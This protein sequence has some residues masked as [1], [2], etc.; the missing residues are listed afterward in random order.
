MT[1][2]GTTTIIML[3]CESSTEPHYWGRLRT[4]GTELIHTVSSQKELSDK[5]IIHEAAK[6]KMSSKRI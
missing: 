4:A 3:D 6:V 5:Y 2:F 1:L